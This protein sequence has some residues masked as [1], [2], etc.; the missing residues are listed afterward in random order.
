M[1]EKI[2]IKAMLAAGFL[3]LLVAMGIG[4]FAYT[5]LLPPMMSEYGFGAEEAGLLASLN[6][7]GYLVGA[8][9]AAALCRALGDMRLLMLGLSLS[10]LTTAGT[11][12]SHFY[13]LVALFRSLAGLASGFCF[14]A[15][16]GMVLSALARQGRDN[17]AG[18]FYAGV[19][20]G[21]V[22]AGLL[23]VPLVD[24]FGA[25]GAW[26]VLGLLSASL[27]FFARRLLHGSHQQTLSNQTSVPAPLPRSGRFVRLTAA[28]GLEG[29]GYIITGTFLVA[30]ARTTFDSA[31]AA[32]VWIV[33]GCAAIPS[34]LLWSLAARRYGTLRPLVAAYV[35][36]AIGIVLPVFFPQPAGVLMGAILFGGTFMGIVGL[37]L[38]SGGAM[39]P[40]ARGRVI[41]L[42][43]GVYGIGQ[44]IGP[45][46]AG[47][48]AARTGS[49]DL[50][51]V[52]AAAAVSAG[53]LL[54]LP[55]A[56]GRKG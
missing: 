51:L 38:A 53:A 7:L 30:A 18:L 26:I 16:S 9:V 10:V 56:F 17:L 37:A 29:F 19:G 39:L 6:Y 27:S 50:S 4:R 34:A 14:V 2:A 12:F 23:A 11:G 1:T 54:L 43:T 35:L 15:I 52:I 3:V 8:F 55:D 42:M 36:Q 21:I 32:G 49:F 45:S 25:A 20:S 47:V 31:G 44:I 46:V 40:S 22:L 41:G 5:P 24:Y 13:P 33:A 28:Y 48:I